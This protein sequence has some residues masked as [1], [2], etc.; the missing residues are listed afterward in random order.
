MITPVISFTV[1]LVVQALHLLHHRLAKRH[2]SF[3]EGAAAA[4]LC[5]PM[6]LPVPDWCFVITH[7]GLAI[8][9][10]TGSI[11][12]TRFSPDWEA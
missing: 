5:V 11:W 7:L 2:I 10:V 9:Q 12:I 6:S 4:V 3:V 1:L 8:V